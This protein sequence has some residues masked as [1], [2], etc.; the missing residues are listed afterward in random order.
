MQEL[1]PTFPRVDLVL[2]YLQERPTP[3]IGENKII[4]KTKQ[5]NLFHLLQPC[6]HLLCKVV[7]IIIFIIHTMSKKKWEETVSSF[8][9]APPTIFTHVSAF[10]NIEKVEA[11]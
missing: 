5:I 4:I 11:P 6:L 8:H 9:K 3:L 10:G 2:Q 1:A 7:I